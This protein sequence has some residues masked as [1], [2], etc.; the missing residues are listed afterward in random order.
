[1][2]SY[3]GSEDGP[4]MQSFSTRKARKA[5]A[6]DACGGLIRPGEKYIT[7]VVIGYRGE[8]PQTHRCCIPCDETIDS[9]MERHESGP[10]ASYLR[11]ALEDCISEEPE[12]ALTWRPMLDAMDVRRKAVR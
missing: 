12:S 11:G 1:M 4:A 3:G 8:R 5:Y 6:C 9:F 7:Q 10:F 2:C